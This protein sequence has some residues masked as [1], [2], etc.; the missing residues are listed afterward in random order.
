MAI[1][2]LPRYDTFLFTEVYDNA[3]D[4]LAD[5]Q[6]SGL[7]ESGWIKDDSITKL[8]YLL[9]ATYGNSPIANYDVNQFKYKMWS[10]IFRDGP[11]WEKRLGIQATLRGLTEAEL[12]QGAKAIYNHAFNPSCDPSTSS[13]TELDYINDQNTTNY[14]KSKLDAYGQLWEIL[15]LD[16]TSEFIG[17]FKE[18]FKKFVI[19]EHPTLFG[20]E[21]E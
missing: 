11:S 18:C 16:I 12:M 19:P 1:T 14:Q 2:R 15:K 17:K 20:T 3:D 5:W 21:E 7:Y 4:F 10:I 13:L 6:A 9:Y 8:Y